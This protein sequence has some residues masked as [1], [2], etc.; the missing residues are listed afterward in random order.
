MYKTNRN[1][2][3]FEVALN[4]SGINFDAMIAENGNR[5]VVLNVF[6]TNFFRK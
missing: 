6:P 4:K 5:T 1:D 3:V 2:G